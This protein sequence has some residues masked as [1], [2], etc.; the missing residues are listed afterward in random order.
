MFI[1]FQNAY[2]IYNICVTICV[3]IGEHMATLHQS[4]THSGD[5]I[6]L[7]SEHKHIFYR[8]NWIECTYKW[9]WKKPTARVSDRPSQLINLSPLHGD[10]LRAATVA[11][12]LPLFNW[13][14]A[15]AETHQHNHTTRSVF[16]RGNRTPRAHR[17]DPCGSKLI[18]IICAR[19]LIVLWFIIFALRG[20]DA[21]P[22]SPHPERARACIHAS[23]AR[24]KRS[25]FVRTIY[26]S[27]EL[28]WPWSGFLWFFASSRRAL[29]LISRSLIRAAGHTT[30]SRPDNYM[31]GDHYYMG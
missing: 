2:Y 15:V 4:F 10:W 3:Q 5:R 20:D 25:Q 13:V 1:I 7:A 22:D 14:I 6:S 26:A 30:R 21:K 28:N 16:V 27:D 8:T 29:W 19:S 31:G 12:P 17:A 18:V 11:L 24:Q 9:N 23:R